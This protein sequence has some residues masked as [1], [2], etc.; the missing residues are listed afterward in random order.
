MSLES[1]NQSLCV[2][3]SSSFFKQQGMNDLFEVDNGT[4]IS[5]AIYSGIMNMHLWRLKKALSQTMT[6]KTPNLII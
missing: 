2:S 5:F 3:T 1:T 4:V 6:C